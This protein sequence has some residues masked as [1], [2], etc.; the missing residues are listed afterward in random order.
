MKTAKKTR[1]HAS[2]PSFTV[3]VQLS[4][5]AASTVTAEWRGEE[6]ER[7]EISPQ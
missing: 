5:R 7:A 1:R 3:R 2:F 4:L 6:E